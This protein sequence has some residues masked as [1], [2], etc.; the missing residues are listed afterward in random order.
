[1]EVTAHDGYELPC[2]RDVEQVWRRLDAVDAG[3][4]DAHEL[5]CPHC[6]TAGE[7]L[8]RLRRVTGELVAEEVAPPA[9]LSGRIMA[10]VRA[11]VRRREMIPLPTDEP[12]AVEVS[13][14]AVASVLRFAADTVPGVRARRCRVRRAA[15][16]I[17]VRLSV[18]V[19]AHG[20]AAVRLEDVRARVLAA[21]RSR[22]GVRPV[23]LDL[24]VDDLY[25]A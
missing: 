19:S 4:A 22:I 1:M 24:V 17:E 10:A 2:G 9:G 23:R 21:A 6:R 16:G 5:E 18:A 11:E 14:Q 12:G 8:R 7:G 25:D 13:D 20:F 3:L 15:D